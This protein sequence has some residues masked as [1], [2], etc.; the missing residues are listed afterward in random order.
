M[1]YCS[2]GLPDRVTA[3]LVYMMNKRI[4]GISIQ[5]RN[6]NRVNVYLDGEFAFGLA[7]IV[8]AWLEIGQELSLE[9]IEVLKLEDQ[10]EA[11][12]QQAITYLGYRPRSSQE[13][14]QYLIKKDYPELII[15]ETL[16][17]LMNN[18]LINDREFAISWVENRN[19]FRPRGRRALAYELRSRGVPEI[20]IEHTLNKLLSDEE[21]LAYEAGKK[22]VRKL[23][24]VEQLEFRRKLSGY[25]SRRGFDYE[26]AVPVVEQLWQE[27]SQAS[28]ST[29]ETVE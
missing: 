26:T 10:K 12:L 19:E 28:K 7:R 11:A 24:G 2:C 17:R 27:I 8:A 29:D 4:T 15:V 1:S 16:E 5:K 21:A 18:G 3:V 25:L 6:P 20:D 13:V 9:K 22:Y 23:R 14:K